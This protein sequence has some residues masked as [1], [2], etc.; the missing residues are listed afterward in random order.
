MGDDR[1]ISD[2]F[3]RNGGHGPHVAMQEPRGKRYTSKRRQRLR[4]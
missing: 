2:V 3:D 1:E 4:F